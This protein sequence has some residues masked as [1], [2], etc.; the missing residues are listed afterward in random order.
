MKRKRPSQRL[1]SQQLGQEPRKTVTA[2]NVNPAEALQHTERLLAYR[3]AGLKPHNASTTA[4]MEKALEEY[5]SIRKP[6]KG[7]RVPLFDNALFCPD[8]CQKLDINSKVKK[9]GHGINL[10]IT[11]P[12][13]EQAMDVRRKLLLLRERKMAFNTENQ[14]KAWSKVRVGLVPS[15]TNLRLQFSWPN[16]SAA[17]LPAEFAYRALG[18][19]PSINGKAL[20]RQLVLNLYDYDAFQRHRK[21]QKKNHNYST[22]NKMWSVLKSKNDLAKNQTERLVRLTVIK[23]I[24]TL[25][26]IAKRIRQQESQN[27]ADRIERRRI[28]SPLIL[29]FT[30]ARGG[31]AFYIDDGV[32]ARAYFP[33]KNTPDAASGYYRD[34]LK[35]HAEYLKGPGL[36]NGQRKTWASM[37][38][39][40]QRTTREVFIDPRGYY[41]R[42]K[43]GLVA[44]L[45]DKGG[46]SVVH[47]IMNTEGDNRFTIAGKK[48]HFR[49][50]AVK[51]SENGTEEFLE[52]LKVSEIAQM[53]VK[54]TNNGF[55]AYTDFRNLIYGKNG[56][57]PFAVATR[58]LRYKMEGYL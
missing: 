45:P 55:E 34:I 12:T 35:R 50:G 57:G 33:V 4:H 16:K 29:K 23:L 10:K 47:N 58:W 25:I 14:K 54:N 26:E 1:L 5:K 13:V 32:K 24:P 15:G 9:N 22:L 51:S 2:K 28:Q 30:Y 3:Y 11:Y 44:M 53:N 48:I 36:T 56:F 17:A 19:S 38:Y 7:V 43:T 21:K 27:L 46:E 41:G 49:Q 42:Q 31:V 52:H 37:P 20:T 40:P 8:G 18:S 6:T 39:G